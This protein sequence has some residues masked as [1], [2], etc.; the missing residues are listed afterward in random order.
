MS[1]NIKSKMYNSIDWY[2]HS[3][4]TKRK[5]IQLLSVKGQYKTMKPQQFEIWLLKNIEGLE[6]EL[7]TIHTTKGN[8]K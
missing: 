6:S 5:L 1:S 2:V 3:E 4:A 8:T 7:E